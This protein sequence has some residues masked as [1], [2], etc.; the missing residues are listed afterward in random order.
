MSFFEDTRG[1]LI[2][3]LRGLDPR[4]R[5]TCTNMAG[6]PSELTQGTLAALVAA[7]T[8]GATRDEAACTAG[9][10]RRALFNWIA[11]GKT[12]PSGPFHELAEAAEIPELVLRQRRRDAARARVGR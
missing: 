2:A 12:E 9:V 10:S 7:L 1:R 5:A 6:R 8:V 4:E 11:R 3:I